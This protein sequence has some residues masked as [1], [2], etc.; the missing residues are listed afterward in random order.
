VRGRKWEQVASFSTS[1][2]PL[3][4]QS[5]HLVD[6]C[7]GQGHLGRTLAALTD[8]PVTVLD[9]DEGL[10]RR[11][12]ELAGRAGVQVG[13]V[14]DDAL[15]PEAR[16]HLTPGS[17]TVALHACGGLTIALIAG[18]DP[19]VVPDVAL[20]PCC[21]HLKHGDGHGC[22]PLSRQG[23]AAAL[24]LDHT[25]LRLATSD[26]VLATAEQRARRR[27]ENAWR[28]GLDLLL[29]EAS[30]EDRY[31][32]LGP[33]SPTALA[34]PFGGFCRQ[35]AEERGLRLPAAW[36][37]EASRAAG[38]QRAR[39]ARALAL[40]R[41]TF[42]R[43]LELWLVLDRALALVDRGYEVGVGTFCS[44]RVT[45]RNLLIRGAGGG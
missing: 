9:H 39:S 36:S 45:P 14:R 30:G 7:G 13:F 34:L 33:L 4:P 16:R 22:L 25:A 44:P 42:R 17:A 2:L 5:T 15:R 29:R 6:W 26:E 18:L 28:L 23:R 24:V 27:R 1:L 12:L 37:P 43:S 40:V 41:A 32:P 11:A 3:S 20:A 38:E 31:S 21:F 8:R 35:V 10:E 19:A